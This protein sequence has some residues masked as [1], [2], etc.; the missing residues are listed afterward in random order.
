MEEV[1][2]ISFNLD[3]GDLTEQ[4]VDDIIRGI[5]EFVQDKFD[6]LH[7]DTMLEQFLLVCEERKYPIDLAKQIVGQIFVS[8]YGEDTM[9]A[10]AKHFSEEDKT[11]H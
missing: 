5:V 4:E 7:D 8:I 3:A 1:F 11:S 9:A 10:I 2:D 6:N